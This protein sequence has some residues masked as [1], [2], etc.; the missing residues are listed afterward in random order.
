VNAFERRAA[1]AV[2]ALAGATVAAPAQPLRALLSSAVASGEPNATSIVLWTRVT[3]K[4]YHTA[5]GVKWAV[6]TSIDFAKPVATGRFVTGASRDYTV[7]VLASGLKPSTRYFYRF[8]QGSTVSPVGRFKLP[9]APGQP[10]A[11]L[12]YAVVSCSNWG[13]GYFNVYDAIS[14]LKDLDF[15]VHLGD[16]MWVVSCLAYVASHGLQRCAGLPRC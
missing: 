14:K 10:Q 8:T 16:Y 7:K 5:L 3:P 13:W 15:W 11:K 4:K 1:C 9:A 6:S 2:A 12:K